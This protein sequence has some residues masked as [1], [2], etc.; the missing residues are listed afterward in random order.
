[1]S[2]KKL[3]NKLFYIFL[4]STVNKSNDNNNN[5]NKSNNNI[6]NNKDIVNTLHNSEPTADSVLISSHKHRQQPAPIT[7]SRKIRIAGKK[8]KRRRRKNL[9]KFTALLD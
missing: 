6:N 2:R 7:G 3:S 4:V 1:M 8:N 9:R 5:N